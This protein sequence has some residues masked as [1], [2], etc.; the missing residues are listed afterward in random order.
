MCT[1]TVRARRA[2]Y[3]IDVLHECGG[4]RAP[5]SRNWRL[6]ANTHSTKPVMSPQIGSFRRERKTHGYSGGRQ[7]THLALALVWWSWWPRRPSSRRLTAGWI[8]TGY[9]GQPE[10]TEFRR[11]VR[12]HNAMWRE[13]NGYP[14]GTHR[15]RP[16][17]PPRLVGSHLD[18]DF[19]RESG[20]NFLTTNARSP[21]PGPARRSSSRTR[22][23]TTRASGPTCFPPRRWRST[24]SGTSPP[25]S[26]EPTEPFT[27]GGPTTPGRV[28]EVR[29]AHSPGRFDPSYS[30]SRALL[31][32]RVR[33]RPPRRV[34]RRP[35]DR[36]Q[37]PRGGGAPQCE[38]DPHAPLR[39]DPRPVR[40]LRAGRRRRA[41]A[42]SD[43]R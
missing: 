1:R 9:L 28:T 36:R 19:A 30:N 10:M 41:Q 16:G 13:A 32:R 31:R 17:T 3:L 43:S 6:A 8:T 23:S 5:K 39:R 14:I 21:R 27:R 20:A 12:Y 34:Q 35:G 40:R 4:T 29:F 22:S 7:R 24:C 25:T 11:A 15:S 38:A 37:V 42:V 33:P 18:L 2:P 26:I